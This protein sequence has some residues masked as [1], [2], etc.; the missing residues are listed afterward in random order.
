MSNLLLGF[1]LLVAALGIIGY[2]GY[3]LLG[4]LP[5]S[6]STML[7]RQRIR[8]Y[9]ARANLGDRHLNS[10]NLDRALAEFQAALYPHPTFSRELAKLVAAHHT[11][12]LSRFVA[13]ADRLQDDRVRLISL[14]KADRLLQERI[15]L[16]RR[17]LEARGA[18]RR[19]IR[20]QF[21]DNTDDLRITLAKLAA[22]IKAQAQEPRYH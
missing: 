19:G 7:E 16:Q 13:A 22:E 4:A 17:Y 3:L 6:F 5:I 12:L 14:A 21:S 20:R 8:I 15:A 1:I 18:S 9:L 10:G 11:G 2:V